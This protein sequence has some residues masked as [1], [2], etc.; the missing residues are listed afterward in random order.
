MNDPCHCNHHKHS[1][2][3]YQNQIR[4]KIEEEEEEEEEDEEEEEEECRR[5]E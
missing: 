3:P 1:E 4:R 2:T 5:Q